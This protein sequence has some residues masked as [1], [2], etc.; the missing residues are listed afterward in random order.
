M[1]TAS[2]KRR[3]F[4]YD[5]GDIF[6]DDSPSLSENEMHEYAIHYSLILVS[7]KSLTVKF[8][9]HRAYFDYNAT[10]CRDFRIT[11]TKYS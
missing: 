11:D 5:F 4:T 7:V 9:R 2:R 10:R 8:S 1:L 6:G 3:L